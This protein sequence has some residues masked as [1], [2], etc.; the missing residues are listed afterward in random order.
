MG[1][2]FYYELVRLA[3][4]P[5]TMI[6]RCGYIVAVFVTLFVICTADGSC[7]PGT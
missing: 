1:A 4:R 3:R 2:L 7:E 6:I 5:R